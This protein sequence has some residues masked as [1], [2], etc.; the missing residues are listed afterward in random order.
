[1][2]HELRLTDLNAAA[3]ACGCGAGACGHHGAAHRDVRQ[4]SAGQ[5]FAVLGMTCGHCVTSVTEEVGALGGVERVD[6]ELAPGGA[7]TVV[8]TAERALTRD[9]IRAA[10]EDAGYT[11]AAS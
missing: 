8:V 9:E 4:S 3:A 11:L 7:S 5:R 1:M 10:V 2:V 6:V